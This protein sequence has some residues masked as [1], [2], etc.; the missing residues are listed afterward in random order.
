MPT[1]PTPLYLT[2]ADL[3]ERLANGGGAGARTAAQLPEPRLSAHSA[4]AQTA[5]VGRLT[6]FTI[7]APDASNPEPPDMLLDIIAGHAGYTATLEH[8]GSQPLEERDPV[9]LRYAWA[10]EQLAD[11]RRGI[12]VVDGITPVE[13]GNPDDI[14]GLPESYQPPSPYLGL[15]EGLTD[16]GYGFGGYEFGRSWSHGR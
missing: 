14:G 12:L 10:R 13:A 15:A 6:A 8:Y 5:V 1:N 11:L 7:P 3:Q 16:D 2:A 4:Q 9:V